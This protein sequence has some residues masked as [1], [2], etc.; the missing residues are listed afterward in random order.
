[1]SWRRSHT[2]VVTFPLDRGE[3]INMTIQS[4]FPPTLRPKPSSSTTSTPNRSIQ[5][6]QSLLP[7][8]EGM[9][10]SP[11]MTHSHLNDPPTLPSLLM[12][13]RREQETAPWQ[14]STKITER[15]PS[16]NVKYL[17]W[18]LPSA[19]HSTAFGCSQPADKYTWK[20]YIRPSFKR[21][22]I[23]QLH[24]WYSVFMWRWVNTRVTSMQYILMLTSLLPNTRKHQSFL[25]A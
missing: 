6:E 2:R 20:M 25:Q 22:K 1:M 19:L 14:R 8:H 7:S 24:S 10:P 5:T 16:G 18:W 3:L 21:N 17:L 9:I 4:L 11:G 13:Q 15:A 23:C 12:V